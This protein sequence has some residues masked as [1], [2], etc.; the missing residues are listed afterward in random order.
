MRVWSIE[1]GV[2]GECMPWVGLSGLAQP[3]IK[4]GAWLRR[5]LR[6]RGRDKSRPYLPATFRPPSGHHPAAEDS[7]W[8]C[9]YLMHRL[10]KGGQPY[11]NPGSRKLMSAT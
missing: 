5:A 10:T 7:T 9:P 4:V 1:Y 11:L 8:C 3:W 2:S 6:R